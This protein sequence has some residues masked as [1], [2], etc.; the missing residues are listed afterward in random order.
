MTVRD[1]VTPHQAILEECLG[2][3]IR[4]TD[5]TDDRLGQDLTHFSDDGAWQA[6]ENHLWLNEVSVYRLKPACVRLFATVANGYHTVTEESLM[7]YGYN[8]NDNNHQKV[9]MS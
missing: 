3:P 8:P 7:Q 6:I 2:T 4:D 1:W 9:Q 5:F